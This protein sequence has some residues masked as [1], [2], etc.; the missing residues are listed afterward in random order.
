MAL[1]PCSDGRP[2]Q[3]VR[4]E[5]ACSHQNRWAAGHNCG[6]AGGREAHQLLVLGLARQTASETLGFR[7]AFT[8]AL[9]FINVIL[10]ALRITLW[11]LTVVEEKL[12]R[13]WG[14]WQ[15]SGFPSL[16]LTCWPGHISGLRA[17]L[18]LHHRLVVAHTA[19]VLARDIPGNGPPG[20][21]HIFLSTMPIE[22][23]I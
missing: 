20:N 5:S 14:S 1:Q 9:M 12:W 16:R 7:E 18:A 3:V 21:E 11:W 17:P 15:H 8:T 23:A 19:L 2:S 6:P 13:K 4:Q 22:I 10:G